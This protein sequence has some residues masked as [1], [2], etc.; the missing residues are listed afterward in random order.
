MHGTGDSRLVQPS[1]NVMGTELMQPR[2]LRHLAI[3]VNGGTGFAGSSTSNSRSIISASAN[4]LSVSQ[5]PKAS[6]QAH[7]R[8]TD[9]NPPKG[10]K[11]SR[12][13]AVSDPMSFAP[14]QLVREFPNESLTLS[15][16]KL[17]RQGCREELSLKNCVVSAHLQSAKH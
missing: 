17:F 13:E 16:G 11:R 14:C 10:K 12:G 5:C 7:K 8:T 2:V 15:K 3:G 4:L 1:V 6:E 9:C